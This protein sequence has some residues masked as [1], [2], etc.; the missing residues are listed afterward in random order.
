MDRPL[1]YHMSASVSASSIFAEHSI[2]KPS[3]DIYMTQK[4]VL[5]VISGCALLLIGTV[6]SAKDNWAYCYAV[7]NNASIYQTPVFA[8]PSGTVEKDVPNDY[9]RFLKAKYKPDGAYQIRCY[10]N[11]DT[12]SL[13]K[14]KRNIENYAQSNRI[15]ATLTKAPFE[16]PSRPAST[17]VAAT[18]VEPSRS[19]QAPAS[20]A[21][22]KPTTQSSQQDYIYCSS[23]ID[24]SSPGDPAP[25]FFVSPLF[26]VSHN[27]PGGNWWPSVAGNVK[28]Q[29]EAVVQRHN[30]KRGQTQCNHYESYQLASGKENRD[31]WIRQ[32]SQPPN[33]T[34]PVAVRH[35]DW[36]YK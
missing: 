7:H 14:T 25:E 17:A 28:Q 4:Q 23:F 36:T 32:M 18:G 31:K 24:R 30:P 10:A 3:L 26:T 2:R 27:A 22:E 8:L 35:L 6:A 33:G 12:S 19:I 1:C 20:S 5:S 15:N 11:T 13:E 16:A 21:N 34:T 29:W 9:E